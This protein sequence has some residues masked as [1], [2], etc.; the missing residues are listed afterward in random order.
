MEIKGKDG[1]LEMASFDQIWIDNRF[2]Y[3]KGLKGS[4]MKLHEATGYVE[5]LDRR[6]FSAAMKKTVIER[7]TVCSNMAAICRSV[8]IDIQSFYDAVAV[9]RKFREDVIRCDKDTKR[10][11]RL[12]DEL[13]ELASS[14]RQQT[15]ADLNAR[16]LKYLGTQ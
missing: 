3:R 8:N 15:I 5:S 7:F 10:S 4:R 6:G 16:R 13:V 1:R 12:N 9:D 14:E 2:R 11:K